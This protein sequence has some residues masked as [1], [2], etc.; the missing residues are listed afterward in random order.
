M[1]ANVLDLNTLFETQVSFRI[2]QFQRPY[3]WKK[4]KQWKPLWDDVRKFAERLIELE[5]D[6]KDETPPHFM[7]AIVLQLR[8]QVTGEVVK[9]LV[10]D[11]QQ[12]LTTLQL[13]IQATQEEFQNI[14]ETARANRLLQLT[15]NRENYWGGDPNNETKIRQSNLNDQSAFQQ[16]IRGLDYGQGPT[17]PIYEAHRYFKQE[18]NDW[19][20][21]RPA[22]RTTRS[23]ALEETLTK[24]LQIAAIDLDAEE[25]PHF[26]FGVLNTRGETLTQSDL[27]KNTVMYEADVVDDAQSAKS[28]WGM[29]D[30]DEWWREVTKEGRISRIHLDRFLNYWMVMSATK[31]ITA[32]RV[33]AEFSS[34]V[35]RHR[36]SRNIHQIAEDIRRCGLVYK[37]IEKA[38]IPGFEVFLRRIK[39]ME[40]GVVVPPLLWLFTRDVAEDSR[41]RAVQALESYLIRR[42][43]CGLQSQGLNRLFIELLTSLETK[44]GQPPDE[45]IIDFLKN[46]T[47]DN[48]IWPRNDQLLLTVATESL[49]GTVG[50]Q[51]MVLEAIERHLRSDKTEDLGQHTFTR[52]HIMPQNWDRHWPL[53]MNISK[54]VNGNI[55]SEQEA[56]DFRGSLLYRIGNLTLVT[57]KLNSSLSNG[58][59]I[60]KRDALNKHT[61]LRLNWE[62]L[63]KYYDNWNEATIFE[64]TKQLALMVCEIWP[65]A[66]DI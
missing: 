32:E 55:S 6:A 15:R 21:D 40:L 7:G 12:R 8:S 35:E 60:E 16:S 5:E 28:L 23:E 38:Q 33:S 45:A 42:M 50:R 53:D 57:G 9:R 25:K 56:I 30:G 22:E 48:R 47:V 13:L 37:D 58:P 19:L 44:G 36:F 10:V 24:H 65:F 51:I 66:D 2:P 26:I 27:V 34:Y 14:N 17:H 52:E 41:K 31:D 39:T 54:E 1:D 29:F 18:V 4:E 62:L 46:Q 11:G 64:R 3:A 59:W 63:D 61:T 43:L 20:N 49:K